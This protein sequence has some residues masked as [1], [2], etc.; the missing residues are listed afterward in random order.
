MR[1]VL[2]ALIIGA[3]VGAVLTFSVDRP[4]H[5]FLRDACIINHGTDC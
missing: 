4:I 3:T 1:V 2:F 5:E